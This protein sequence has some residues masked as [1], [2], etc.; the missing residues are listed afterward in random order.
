MRSHHL[1]CFVLL[2]S[3]IGLSA[4]TN[5]LG[6]RL[7]NTSLYLDPTE[8]QMFGSITGLVDQDLSEYQYIPFGFGGAQSI[9]SK[10]L[11]ENKAWEI[12]GE[13][14]AFTQFEWKT[15]NNEQQRNLL[16]TDYRI[17]F[18]YARKVSAK[19]TYRFRFFHVSSHLGDD[20]IIRTGTRKF[21]TNKVNYEQLEF[22]YFRNFRK[23]A[24][25]YAGFGSVVRPN[26]SRLPFSYH[27]GAHQDFR[28]GDKK[29]GWTLGT[30][31]KG[32]QETDFNPNLKIG[33]GPSYFATSKAVPLR[34][35]LEYYNGHLPYSQFEENEIEW[36][37]LG[38]YFNL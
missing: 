10:Q 23:N 5:W 11:E 35:V 22:T 8:I 3:C 24:R 26:S 25:W 21:T 32:F 34:L 15:V 37:G 28:K 6:P 38:L 17:T 12:V 4:Q 20:Y 30:L 27:L 36:L 2:F 29:W 31:I 7:T 13:L 18:A 14:G 9:V 19:A 16:N 1:L 33:F